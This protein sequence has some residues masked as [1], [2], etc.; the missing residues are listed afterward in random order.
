M[1]GFDMVEA[2]FISGGFQGKVPGAAGGTFELK[3]LGIPTVVVS[4]GPAGLRIK[5]RDNDVTPIM[6]L[7][8]PLELPPLLG[9]QN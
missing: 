8:F 7:P 9:I 5:L 3:R 1:P 6:Q 2:K 4:D